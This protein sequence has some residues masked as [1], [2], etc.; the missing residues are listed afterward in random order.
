MNIILGGIALF[1]GGKM[2]LNRQ[3]YVQKHTNPIDYIGHVDKGQSFVR[4]GYDEGRGLQDIGKF[5]GYLGNR[6]YN[7]GP[8]PEHQHREFQPPTTY[9]QRGPTLTPKFYNVK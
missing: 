7:F 9:F 1:I 2:L 4:G 8:N 6:E 5:G 3:R